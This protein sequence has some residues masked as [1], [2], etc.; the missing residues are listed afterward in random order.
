MPRPRPSTPQSAAPQRFSIRL[1]P[2]TG[3]TRKQEE[4]FERQLAEYLAARE[5]A[6]EGTQLRMDILPIER[7]LAVQDLANLACWIMEQPA[8]GAVH[9]QMT[10]VI[11]TSISRP[12]ATASRSDRAVEP[13]VQL[14]RMGR[15]G[16]AAFFEVLRSV[17]PGPLQLDAE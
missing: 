4:D 15:I 17:Q 10:G 14:H 9:V 3:L 11:P 13:L 1:Q 8:V 7:E 16:A 12:W 2:S 6:A 5:L